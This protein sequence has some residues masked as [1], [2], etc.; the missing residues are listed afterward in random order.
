[1]NDEEQAFCTEHIALEK[2]KAFEPTLQNQVQSK[3]G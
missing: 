1:M 3:S 2:I